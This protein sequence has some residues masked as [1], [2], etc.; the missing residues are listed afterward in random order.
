MARPGVAKVILFFISSGSPSFYFPNRSYVT[1]SRCFCN[2]HPSTPK[3]AL[4]FSP[5]KQVPFSIPRCAQDLRL[6]L[7]N[8][9]ELFPFFFS[10]DAFRLSAVPW[11]AVEQASTEQRGRAITSKWL[12]P[13]KSDRLIKSG[14]NYCGR[15]FWFKL[16]RCPRFLQL[17]TIARHWSRS[18][19]DFDFRDFCCS[20][21]HDVQVPFK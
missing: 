8:P 13:L 1:L 21:W 7:T 15:R 20:I 19:N 4:L 10:V 11:V 9:C 5:A 3:S 16:A 17:E 2:F 12:T 14:R 18:R 6:S